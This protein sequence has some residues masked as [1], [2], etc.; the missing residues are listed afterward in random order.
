MIKK[1]ISFNIILGSIILL[2]LNSFDVK[3]QE[4]LTI[5]IIQYNTLMTTEVGKGIMTGI[6]YEAFKNQN[7]PVRFKVYPTKRIPKV[8]ET[9][10]VCAGMG[11]KRWFNNVDQYSSVNF[12]DPRL[13]AFYMK[14]RYPNGVPFRNVEDLKGY[15]LGYILGGSFSKV[16]QEKQIPDVEYVRNNRSNIQKLYLKRIDLAVMTLAAGLSDITHLYPQEKEKFG[17]AKNSL[18]RIQ[19][20]LVFAPKCAQYYDSFRVGLANIWKNGVYKSIIEQYYN[21]D[22]YGKLSV[23]TELITLTAD[24][25]K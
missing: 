10:D 23:P 1:H 13:R 11:G 4:P 15:V 25:K 2:N 16:L 14:D 24:N 9:D 19:G 17:I 8:L 18:M 3:A 21:F 7:L 22:K 12:Y 6:V 20:T 5:A